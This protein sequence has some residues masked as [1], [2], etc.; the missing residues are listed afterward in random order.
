MGSLV[1]VVTADP[2]PL[3]GRRSAETLRPSVAHRT[4]IGH[5]RLTSAGRQFHHTVGRSCSSPGQPRVLVPSHDRGFKVR[6]SLIRQIEIPE[7]QH[8]QD[9]LETHVPDGVVERLAVVG[10]GSQVCRIGLRRD[11]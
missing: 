5:S 10:S 11:A 7:L 1:L 9:V 3:G 2:T 8:G 4:R 6:L